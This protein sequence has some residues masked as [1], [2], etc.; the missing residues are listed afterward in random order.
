[1]KT[2]AD[3]IRECVAKYPDADNAEIRM[4]AAQRGVSVQANHITAVVGPESKR[5]VKH[6]IDPM[7][8]ETAKRLMVDAGG[9]KQ[10]RNIIDL[11]AKDHRHVQR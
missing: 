3:L 4:Y 9:A 2:K 7:M 11:V 1:M 8:I 10:A 6:R 5:L